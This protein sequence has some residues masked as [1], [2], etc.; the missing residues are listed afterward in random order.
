MSLA[1][2][3]AQTMQA[4]GLKS[5]KVA[6]RFS[7]NQDRAT[8]YRLVTGATTEPRLG[9]V[10]QLC[11]ALETTPSELLALAGV[12]SPDVPSRTGPDDL[13]LRQAFT[14]LRALPPD[15][16]HWA[17]SLVTALANA[18]VARTEPLVD[19]DREREPAP[20]DER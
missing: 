19:D 2:A 15:G 17:V 4:H 12:W 20:L 8:F 5:A 18:M 1:H 14:R 11:S 3:I 9:T 10:V 13:R 7:A 6:E 16:R